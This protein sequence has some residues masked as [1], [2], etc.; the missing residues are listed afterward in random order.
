MIKLK[1]RLLTFRERFSWAAEETAV[2]LLKMP[3]ELFS[4][5]VKINDLNLSLVVVKIN[6]YVQ[7]RI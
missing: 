6:F 5:E 2:V 4:K 3:F 1:C 7:E